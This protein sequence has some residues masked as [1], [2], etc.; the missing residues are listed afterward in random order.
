MCLRSGRLNYS[1]A[2]GCRQTH[3][4]PGKDYYLDITVYGGFY[5]FHSDGKP[6]RQCAGRPPVTCHAVLAQLTRRT[7]CP[8]LPGG[9]STR[10][11]IGCANAE[12]LHD[13]A[14]ARPSTSSAFC[15]KR[16][17]YLIKAAEKCWFASAVINCEP[18]RKIGNYNSCLLNRFADD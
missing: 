6:L 12:R 15:S 17:I 13:A 3:G 7:S 8:P 16:G 10:C 11:C 18:F 5:C 9:N 4:F 1:P 2:S 14:Q